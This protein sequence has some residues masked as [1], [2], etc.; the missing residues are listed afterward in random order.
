MAKGC[1]KHRGNCNNCVHGDARGQ[2]F[3]CNKCWHNV[4]D[5]DAPC[6]YKYDKKLEYFQSKFVRI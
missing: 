3:P 6:Y 1:E 4:C 5:E 2:D